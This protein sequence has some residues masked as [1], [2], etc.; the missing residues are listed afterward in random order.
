MKIVILEDEKSVSD[1]LQNYI[2]TY[3]EEEKMPFPS[4]LIFDNAYDLLE[5]NLNG[6]DVYFLDIQ[7]PM[8]NG[9][10]AAKKIREKDKNALIVFVT[11]LAQYAIKGY[12][13]NAFDFILKPVDY[14]G[15]RM[16]LR[17]ILTELSHKDARKHISLKTK[18]G[19]LKLY[20]EE[21]IYIE[22]KGHYLLFHTL[23]EEIKVRAPLKDY[24]DLLEKDYFTLCNKGTLVNLSQVREVKSIY[25][26]TSDGKELLLSQGRKKPFLDELNRYLGGSI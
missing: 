12:E 23:T 1:A 14:Q 13:V 4:L 15:F 26:V 24:V 5:A 7:L 19:I 11:N 22:A 17:R 21:I 6:I 3:F 25:V 16:K 10:D 20:I 18:E 8:M 2:R 9:M